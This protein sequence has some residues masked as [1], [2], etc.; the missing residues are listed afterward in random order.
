[1]VERLGVADQDYRLDFAPPRTRETRIFFA[2]IALLSLNE[3][4]ANTISE[5][6]KPWFLL[7]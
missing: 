6:T 3:S 4:I 2:E 1:V 7:P 5:K